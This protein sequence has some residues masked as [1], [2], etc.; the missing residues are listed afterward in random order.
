[1]G[2]STIFDIIGSIIVAG[3]LILSATRVSGT[4]EKTNFTSAEEVIVQSNLTTLVMMVESDLRKI[5][6]CKDPTKLYQNGTFIKSAG[7]HNLTF[8]TDI[9]NDG[10]VDS[11]SY[12][13]GIPDSL[14]WTGN[15]RDFAL[16]RQVNLNTPV[17][18]YLGLTQFDFLYY[19]TTPPY[20]SLA[21]PISSGYTGIGTI[22]LTLMVESPYAYEDPNGV[23]AGAGQFKNAYWR[24]IR[25]SSPNFLKR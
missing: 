22:R 12:T 6:Y 25:L 10:H 15:P 1:M 5:G 11:V 7:A 14:R 9:N 13:I 2:Y 3:V 8:Y 21:F 17:A 19:S 18:W 16:Y 24:Q 23:H 20:D 4:M